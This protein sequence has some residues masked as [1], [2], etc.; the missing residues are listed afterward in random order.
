MTNTEPL[1][2]V[3][4]LLKICLALDVLPTSSTD[5]NIKER[6]EFVLESVHPNTGVNVFLELNCCSTLSDETNFFSITIS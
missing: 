3:D 1:S 2:I 6:E 5:E 4:R